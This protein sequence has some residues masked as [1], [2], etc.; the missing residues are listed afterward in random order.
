M[1]VKEAKLADLHPAEW[2]PRR[3]SDFQLRALKASL[4]AHGAVEPIVANAD[5]TI[6]GGH[7]R[8]EAALELGWPTFPTFYV[9]LDDE[10]ARRLNIALN[11]ISGE[12]DD[13]L[14]AELVSNI[15][16]EP[17]ELLD[18]G[19]TEDEV[20]ALLDSIG[21]PTAPDA[22]P[23]PSTETDHRCPSCGYEWS[24]PCQ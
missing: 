22:F 11:K 17:V 1:R 15:T 19:F 4:E 9:D 6:L 3:I 10:A 23:P 8:Y 7:Q 24:G 18:V 12:W 13:G 5:G 14:L 16:T 2:N 21:D 20:R